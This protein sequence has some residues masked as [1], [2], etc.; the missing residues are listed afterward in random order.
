[1]Y[2]RMTILQ[3]GLENIDDAIEIFRRSVLPEAR[4]QKGFRGACLLTDRTT[5]KGYSV[6]FWRREADALANEESRFYQEQ[7]VK[8]LPYY[9]HAP[10]RE[11]YTVSV[12]S[13]AARRPSTARSGTRP[14]AR[15]S[16]PRT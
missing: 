3:V 6:T 11:G 14:A 16:R 15:A 7:L 5:G 12:H 10:I 4:K 13:L 2:A 8:A 1:M 9:T